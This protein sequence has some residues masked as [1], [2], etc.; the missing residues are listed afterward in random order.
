[1]AGEASQKN[2]ALR[3][4]EQSRLRLGRLGW[5]QESGDPL[6]VARR[7]V[8]MN[9]ALLGGSV[10]LR[11]KLGEKLRGFIRFTSLG[12]SA[13]FL[14]GSAHGADLDTIESATTNRATGLLCGRT[15]I[16]HSRPRWRKPRGMSTSA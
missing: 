2:N 13:D 14:F 8:L 1:M 11:L 6:L 15:S 5:L 3:G 4:A 9:D 16:S 7:G 12:Q 10:D